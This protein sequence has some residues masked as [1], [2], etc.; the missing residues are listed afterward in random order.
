MVSLKCIH[1]QGLRVTQQK[2]SQAAWLGFGFGLYEKEAYFSQTVAVA[3]C[4]LQVASCKERQKLLQIV[5]LVWANTNTRLE[6]ELYV[7]CAR[8]S[9]QV[10]VCMCVRVF[11]CVCVLIRPPPATQ[12]CQ[13]GRRCKLKMVYEQP[14]TCLGCTSKLLPQP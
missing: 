4:K 7:E 14:A 2:A 6:V 12:T 9:V 1:P 11:P 5:Q 3:S 13:R 10:C 8:I